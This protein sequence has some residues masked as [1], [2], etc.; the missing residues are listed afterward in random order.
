MHAY[1]RSYPVTN[2]GQVQPAGQGTVWLNIG[3]AGAGLYTSWLKTPAWS[4][5]HSA[6]FGHGQLQLVNASAAQWTW[7]RNADDEKIITD[8]TTIVNWAL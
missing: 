1:E 7:H 6:E 8:S 5:Y 4:A 2:N 3:D